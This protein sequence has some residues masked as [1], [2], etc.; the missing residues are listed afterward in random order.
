M[1]TLEVK[2]GHRIS[3][4]GLRRVAEEECMSHVVLFNIGCKKPFDH[5]Y[6]SIFVLGEAQQVN[7]GIST[8]FALLYEFPLRRKYVERAGFSFTQQELCGKK[9]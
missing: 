4:N 3:R 6:H 9:I 8:C 1:T 2:G 7:I 5:C